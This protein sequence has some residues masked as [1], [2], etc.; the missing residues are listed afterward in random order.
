MKNLR[1]FVI[2]LLFFGCS[3]AFANDT[4]FLIPQ[5]KIKP[6]ELETNEIRD[7]FKF[8]EGQQENALKLIHKMK[9]NCSED[10][11]YAIYCVA[12]A[13]ELT[14]LD[15]SLIAA[16]A[17]A[18][19][20]FTTSATSPTGV[21]GVMQITRK[22]FKYISGAS[23]WQDVSRNDPLY[24]TI[25]GAVYIQRL[26]HKYEDEVKA[27]SYYNAGGN[28]SAGKSYALKVLRHKEK[29]E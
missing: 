15:F 5:S 10:N 26:L 20:S 23:G 24:N 16:V 12:V 1:N 14:Q 9:L 29:F 4:L 25:C 19:S 3:S 2:C 6:W 22:V 28:L 13:S 18:E 8:P 7:I 27:L 11:L 21:K 17:F